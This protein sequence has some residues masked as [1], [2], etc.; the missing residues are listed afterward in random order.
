M[1]KLN[2]ETYRG[3]SNS[4]YISREDL[5]LLENYFNKRFHSG[6]ATGEQEILHFLQDTYTGIIEQN[7]RQ[8]IAPKE[9]DL[10]LPEASLAIEHNGIYYHRDKDKNYHLSKLQACKNQGIR[11]IQFW[12]CE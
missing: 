7:N 6:Q 8:V 9:L 3:P 11:L 10:Y 5:P 2:I 4:I 12:D 1:D